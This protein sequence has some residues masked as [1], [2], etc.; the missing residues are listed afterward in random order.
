M[1]TKGDFHIHSTYSDGNC[2]PIQIIKI[3]KRND[4]NII[5]LTD[6]NSMNGVYEAIIE[7]NKKGI[8]VIPGVELSTRFN[9]IRVHV[10]GYFPT[11]VFKND[12]LKS[13]LN[14]VSNHNISKFNKIL[15]NELNIQYRSRKID[16]SKGIEFLKYFGATVILA[17]PVLLPREEFENIASL[18]FDGIEAK[19]SSNNKEDTNFFVN[20]AKSHNLIYTAGSDF[21]TRVELYRA[22]GN[23]GDVFLDKKEISTFLKFLYRKHKC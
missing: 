5:S 17:H 6:H 1:Y 16:T 21:H 4:I 20:Y 19:Y 3:A 10:L 12:I 2:T 13:C 23:I 18:D 8:K 9:T 15:K 22:H 7:G 11:E 14:C